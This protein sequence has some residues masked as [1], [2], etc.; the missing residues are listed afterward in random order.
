[1]DRTYLFVPPEEKADVQSLGAQWDNVSKR[2]FIAEND[3]PSKFS[4]WLPYDEDDEDDEE[5][6]ITSSE[7]YVAAAM[8][9]CQH[10]TATIEVICIHCLTGTA[11]G[12]PLT[13]F[14]I[15]DVWAI[16]DRL[17][18]QLHPWPT[19]HRLGA[20]ATEP[21]GGFANHCPHCGTP[22]D[23]MFLH[24]EPDEPFFDIPNSPPDSFKL[25]PLAGEVQL[26]G[27]EHFTVE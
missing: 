27:D 9:P 19:F 12:E 22:Q 11:S 18:K 25:T 24:T 7:A 2:W 1:M 17:A 21:G 3:P 4:R 14:T 13:R 26:S 8:T 15:S 6:N 16:D 5:F 23:D 10:C 20:S